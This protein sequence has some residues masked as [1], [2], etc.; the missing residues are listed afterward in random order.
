MPSRPMRCGLILAILA[1]A[2]IDVLDPSI[3]NDL[4]KPGPDSSQQPTT[5]AARF[6]RFLNGCPSNHPELEGS[7]EP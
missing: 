3:T 7:T 5:V 4:G 1:K 6:L 2:F